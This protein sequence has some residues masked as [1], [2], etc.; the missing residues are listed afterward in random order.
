MDEIDFLFQKSNEAL[1]SAKSSF[2]NKYY[3]TSINRSYYAVFYA[4]KG[5]LLKKRVKTNK[6]A[7]NIKM[8]GLEY[9]VNDEF[10]EEIAKILSKLEEDRSRADY[11]FDATKI[12]AERNLEKGDCLFFSWDFLFFV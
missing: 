4:S 6:H 10:D 5:L 8:F 9:V 1:E 2:D 7:G 12:K 3:S 11:D